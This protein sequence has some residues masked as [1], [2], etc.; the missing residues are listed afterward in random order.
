MVE[1]RRE[2]TSEAEEEVLQEEDEA[3]ILQMSVAKEIIRAQVSQVA[4]G[5]INKKFN[6][7]IVRSLVIMHE[8]KKKQY[9]QGRQIPNQST[10]AS[11][12]TSAMLMASTSPL[13]CNALQESPHD[14]WYLD[15]GCS[16]HMTGNLNLFFN[17]DNS[18]KTDVTL[19]NNVQVTVL[20]KAL[21]IF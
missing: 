12:S 13:E 9:D 10:N 15:S 1:A 11:T 17:L 6:V 7:I 3:E 19:G 16:N 18:V 8:S 2:T 20:G 14:I 4:R 21:L 5:L